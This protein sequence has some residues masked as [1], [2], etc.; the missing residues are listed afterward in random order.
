MLD[1]RIVFEVRIRNK[2]D[3]CIFA[4][5]VLV[6]KRIIVRDRFDVGA[7]AALKSSRLALFERIQTVLA[8]GAE[9]HPYA[10]IYLSHIEIRFF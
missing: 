7:L 6:H 8:I 1:G 5:I 2:T 9:I 4:E 3:R 10:L